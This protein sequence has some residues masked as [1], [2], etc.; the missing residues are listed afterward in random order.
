[1]EFL[2][3]LFGGGG[4]PRGPAGDPNGYYLYVRCHRCKEKIRVRVNLSNDLAE[5]LSED[6]SDR[7]IGYIAEK[8]VVGNNFMCGQTMRLY[9]HFDTSRR[10][11]SE[12]VDGGTLIT[13]EEFNKED[14]ETA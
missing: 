7:V 1:M 13:E 9:L 2:R 12:R 3:R 8:G 11:I 5:E 14:A 10:P 4:R 6:A